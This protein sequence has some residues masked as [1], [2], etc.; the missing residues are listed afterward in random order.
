VPK[1]CGLALILDAKSAHAQF[2]VPGFDAQVSRAELH[3]GRP[4]AREPD[5]HGPRARVQGQ[6]FDVTL[7][8]SPDLKADASR[9]ARPGVADAVR[10]GCVRIPTPL[11]RAT[12]R[13]LPGELTREEQAYAD[14]LDALRQG[15][16]LLDWQ[17]EPL[18]LRLGYRLHYRPDFGVLYQAPAGGSFFEL[19]E[20]K[21][22]K[23]DELGRSRPFSRE[24]AHIKVKTAATRFW[25]WRFVV[26][27]RD[28]KRAGGAWHAEE[29]PA[30][31]DRPGGAG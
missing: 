3:G 28:T 4:P 2:Q 27:W 26:V 22:G 7:R 31:V 12:G 18:T 15:G 25:W 19:H 24:D 23:L 16:E 13:R 5:A 14:R 9:R 29:V 30:H 17:H 6:G 10:D 21:G 8:T 11:K 20:V 1:P